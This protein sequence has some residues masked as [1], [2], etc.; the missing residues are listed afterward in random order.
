MIWDPLKKLT[1][2]HNK[3]GKLLELKVSGKLTNNPPEVAKAFN[4]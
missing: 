4:H 1:E 3:E 2:N